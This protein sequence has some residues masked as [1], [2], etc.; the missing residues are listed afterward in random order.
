M[1]PLTRAILSALEINFTTKRCRKFNLRLFSAAWAAFLEA[2]MQLPHNAAG[3]RDW[4]R[5]R[6]SSKLRTLNGNSLRITRHSVDIINRRTSRETERE[7]N[8]R[9]RGRRNASRVTGIFALLSVAEL[10]GIRQRLQR[11]STAC[12]M[13]SQQISASMRTNFCRY[14]LTCRVIEQYWPNS[15]A[16]YTIYLFH[17]FIN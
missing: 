10:R 15:S 1:I 12:A 16:Q 13:N 8:R 7:R 5:R 4:M 9:T 3:M 14:R 17:L 2:I 6:C 11:V